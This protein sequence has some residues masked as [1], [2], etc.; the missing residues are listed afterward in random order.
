MLKFNDGEKTWFN[1]KQKIKKSNFSEVARNCSLLLLRKQKVLS[2]NTFIEGL[3]NYQ[4]AEGFK[5]DI[6]L[7]SF[8]LQHSGQT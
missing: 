3:I 4:E 8:T 2:V 7:H 5:I 1:F 6:D